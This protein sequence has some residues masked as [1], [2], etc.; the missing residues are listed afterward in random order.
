MQKPLSFTDLLEKA[1][2]WHRNRHHIFD[3]WC[4]LDYNDYGPWS[5]YERLKETEYWAKTLDGY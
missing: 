5:W 3:L 4:P 2:D 1:S